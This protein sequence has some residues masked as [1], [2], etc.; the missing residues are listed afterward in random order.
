M[1]S[2]RRY[3]Q[4][5]FLLPLI[6]PL[7]A[8]LVASPGFRGWNAVVLVLW[9]SLLI[10]GIPY[11]LFLAG[12]LYWARDKDAK[13]IQRVTFIAPLLLVPVFIYCA[14]AI[15]PLQILKTGEVR[16][17]VSGVL[18]FCVF[19]LVVGYFYVLLANAV[20][21]LL[22]AI[23]FIA[24]EAYWESVPASSGTGL[25]R[26]KY[27]LAFA[28]AL[29]LLLIP[30]AA[31]IKDRDRQNYPQRIAEANR[32]ADSVNRDSALLE[33]VHEQAMAGRYEDAK[34]TVATYVEDKDRGF[35]GIVT[36]Q[37]NRGLYEEAKS[38]ADLIAAPVPRI[39]AY[40]QI[41]VAQAK[42]GDGRGASQTLLTARDLAQRAENASLKRFTLPIIAAGQ[43]EAGL[44]SDLQATLKMVEPSEMVDTL[45]TVALI[46]SKDGK[47][48]EA[49]EYFGE[50]IKQAKE[51]KDPMS[52]DSNLSS[53]SN[54]QADAGLLDDAKAT[55][56]MI[57][58][59]GYKES[60]L[61]H[62]S[63]IE[64]GVVKR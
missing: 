29:P 30:V 40:R 32:I 3:F 38:T 10:G 18:T 28:L 14:V 34:A 8:L 55:A 42:D 9:G 22:K 21:F 24:E 52:K 53:I 5:S 51:I 54:A 48:K 35:A 26:K 46:K 63:L 27:I 2:A 61:Y 39:M 16:V 13:A 4:L 58:L 7:L 19:V 43:A 6:L 64:K 62:I 37:V 59:K 41:A 60:A 57:T 17:E 15:I 12:L 1:I 25:G 44:D 31:L 23:G 50:A 33:I 47:L 36:A 11:V 49:Q 20:F 45:K 56:E